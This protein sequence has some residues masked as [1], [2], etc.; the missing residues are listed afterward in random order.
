[1]FRKKKWK[2]FCWG[3]ER[4]PRVAKGEQGRR[5]KKC[6]EDDET[7][8]ESQEQ[9]ESFAWSVEWDKGGKCK[10]N[11]IRKMTK[12]KTDRSVAVDDYSVARVSLRNIIIYRVMSSAWNAKICEWN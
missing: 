12:E 4:R 7:N 11:D 6:V 2:E 10:E 9:G 8:Q 3:G 1:M 5:K